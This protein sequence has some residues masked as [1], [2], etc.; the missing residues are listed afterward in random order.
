MAEEGRA[1]TER[2][3]MNPAVHL[4]P[5]SRLERPLASYHLAFERS[6]PRLIVRPYPSCAAVLGPL[7][8]V[9]FA[10]CILVFTFIS[11]FV[12][13]LAAREFSLSLL[14]HPL[15][16]RTPGLGKQLIPVYI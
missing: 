16:R 15:R 4:Q 8:L 10:V 2:T 13:F 14:D 1:D 3:L 6:E 12:L 7:V 9:L 5:L 11:R